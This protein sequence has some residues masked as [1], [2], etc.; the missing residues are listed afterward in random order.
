MTGASPHPHITCTAQLYR[1]VPQDI[2]KKEDGLYI[3]YAMGNMLDMRYQVRYNAAVQSVQ[4]MD[5]VPC[6]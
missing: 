2:L 1:P 6:C 3:K 4:H 5:A